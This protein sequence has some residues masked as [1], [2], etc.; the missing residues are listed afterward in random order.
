MSSYI[1]PDIHGC[2]ITLRKLIEDV[3]GVGKDDKLYFLG[4]YIDRGPYSAQLVDYLLDLMNKGYNLNCLRGNHEQMLLDAFSNMS[5]FN[6]WMYN[7][8][9]VTIKSYKDLLGYSF[10]FPVDL[11]INHFHFYSGLSHYI[12]IGS[13]Y[14][15]V[16]AG[17]NFR[18]EKP[19]QDY[20][21]MLWSRSYNI[22]KDFLPGK[23]IIHG[24]TP[25]PINTIKAIINDPESHIIPL[26]A[27]CVFGE[28]SEGLGY[29]VALELEKNKLFSVKKLENS[30]LKIN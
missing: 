4:D 29:L 14:I 18:S 9:N 22:P 21:A 13:R 1:I 20:E 15:L 12:E 6:I 10:L 26:D 8:G 5:N 28:I 16:H 7:T 24:H 17:F 23:I 27:G 3:I 11:P 30:E 25:K 19:M 2:L